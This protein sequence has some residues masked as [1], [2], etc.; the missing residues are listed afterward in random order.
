MSPFLKRFINGLGSALAIGGIVF[1]AMR[2]RDYSAELDLSRLDSWLFVAMGGLAIVYGSANFLLAEAWRQLLIQFGEYPSGK[3]AIRIYGIS[4]IAK[5]LPGNIFHLAGRQAY[6]TSDGYD[7]KALAKSAVWE[8]GLLAVVGGLFSL[9]AV[10]LLSDFVPLPVSWA[11]FGFAM[12]A[13]KKCIDK[14]IGTAAG[15]AFVWQAI[16]LAISGGVFLVLL[17][18]LSG[19]IQVSSMILP[20]IAAAYVVAWLAGLVTPGAPAGVGVREM[21]LLLLLSPILPE[22]TLLLAVVLG[23]AVTVVGDVLFFMFAWISSLNVIQV[24]A[25]DNES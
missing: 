16:F 13:G 11:L 15:R 24:H 10:P 12:V 9:L 23:R 3:W 18:L 19:G 8:L 17:E 22:S 25:L 14:I 2:L 21:V 4:Q 1:A 7:A 20:G 6:G 5:Y